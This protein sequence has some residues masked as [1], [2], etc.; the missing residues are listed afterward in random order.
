MADNKGDSPQS[1][2]SIAETSAS[3]QEEDGVS[4]ALFVIDEYKPFPR[5][6]VEN[7]QK[8]SEDNEEREVY[9]SDISITSSETTAVATWNLS[10]KDD[11]IETVN[12]GRFPVFEEPSFDDF[13]PI[14]NTN[15]RKPPVIIEE[16][17]EE[18]TGCNGALNLT[19]KQLA[20]I[21]LAFE[22]TRSIW[23]GRQKTAEK[24]E[25]SIST[26]PP[27]MEPGTT[28]SISSPLRQN[29][30]MPRAESLAKECI[31][32][33]KI[34]QVDSSKLLTMKQAMEAQRELI[35][36]KEIEI[37][38]RQKDLE[39]SKG[40]LEALTREKEIF[41]ER[42]SELIETIRILKEEVDKLTQYTNMGGA[43]QQRRNMTSDTVSL[44]QDEV[45][46]LK[47]DMKFFSS[48]IVEQDTI[49]DELRTVIEQQ[50]KENAVLK[51]EVESLRKG[52][53]EA[54]EKQ[55]PEQTIE[56]Q[57]HEGENLKPASHGP[58]LVVQNK[59][60]LEA[61]LEAASEEKTTRQFAQPDLGMM[62]ESISKRL[63]AVE[64]E[65]NQTESILVEE[66]K[67]KDSDLLELRNRLGWDTLEIFQYPDE[68]EVLL[69]Q[70]KDKQQ[71][72]PSSHETIWCCDSIAAWDVFSGN[73]D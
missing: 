27:A 24:N 1:T 14:L 8:V 60:N 62:L 54:H 61:V 4:R 3:S 67:K 32:L 53:E 45:L 68:I 64:K 17:P 26:P 10:I 73:L 69:Y 15:T 29:D 25:V 28:E 16:P 47:R 56:H 71:M 31:A 40:R 49:I 57:I 7:I 33:K 66:L 55:N 30:W 9:G 2:P 51:A 6:V 46:S 72:P 13:K 12:D 5:E 52:E 41:R 48:Q 43:V 42:E 59:E 18:P 44:D 11:T 38:D 37:E 65:K 50:D 19:P 58:V 21:F 20:D 63:E 35:T 70:D 39:I 22:G 23:P 36:Q 34:I